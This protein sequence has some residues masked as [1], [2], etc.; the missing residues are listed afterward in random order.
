M[1]AT[2]NELA[3]EIAHSAPKTFDA[4]F[5]RILRLEQQRDAAAARATEL[6]QA[7]RAAIEQFCQVYGA[8]RRDARGLHWVA[9]ARALPDGTR[10]QALMRRGRSGRMQAYLRRVGNPDGLTILELDE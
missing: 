7:L 4:D 3:D 9:P 2:L 5:R 10:I 8:E 6:A 1:S